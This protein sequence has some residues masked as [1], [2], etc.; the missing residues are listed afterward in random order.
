MNW[1]WQIIG[2]KKPTSLL[3]MLAV[4]LLSSNLH[5]ASIDNAHQIE[6]LNY[7]QAL[8]EYFQQHQLKAITG[9]LVAEQKSQ[10][11]K[12][13]DESD[14]LLADLYYAYGLFVESD[15]LFSRLL[16]E[17]TDRALLNRVWFNLARL[18]HDQGIYDQALKLLSQID[19]SLPKH[20]QDEKQYFLTNLFLSDLKFNDASQA[21]QAIDRESIWYQYARYNLGVSL[22]ENKR[23]DE[24]KSQLEP[25]GQL[26]TSSEE[27]LALRDRANLSLGLSQLRNARAEASIASFERIRL[28]GPLSHTALL[29]TGWAWNSLYQFDKA[30]VPWLELARKNTIDPA[31]QEA[32]LAIPTA[33][34]ENQKPKLAVQ[35]YEL[36][37]N[38]FDKQLEVL[39]HS[40]T[41]IQN[42]ELIS[43][44]NENALV[45]EGA[46]YT[47][48]SL[49]SSS[50]PYL[51]ILLASREFQR[52]LKRYQ[53]LI[54]IS[55]TL[56]HWNFNLPTLALML[57]ERRQ[58]F[59]EK[60][61]LLEQTSNFDHLESLN[62][63]RSVF[64]NQ[65]GEIESN[66]DYLGLATVEENEQLQRLNKVSQTLVS[67][68]EQSDTSD[69]QDMHRLLSGLLNWQINTSYASR[70]WAAQKQLN[71]L[72]EALSVATSRADSLRQITASSQ[73]KFDDFEL[74]IQTQEKKIKGLI[75]RIVDLIER[76]E[77]L[78]VRLAISAIDV[79]KQHIV[80]L[81]LNARYALARLY[82]TMVSE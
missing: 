71:G 44:L 37:A 27:T 73:Q 53:E 62:K 77:K 68:G 81:R 2:D 3:V 16:N 76:Q 65:L 18:N 66:K 7:G 42:G 13:R 75:Q 11:R 48:T 41:T 14:L 31:T 39:D 70:L 8:F 46:E 23:L 56:N 32:L 79:Q 22:L 43:L 33:L 63:S 78:I 34:E 69:E 67:I 58:R 10:T 59:Q 50:A 19:D 60:L 26:Q 55:S 57:N 35:Y 30:L 15:R 9:L 28:E 36:A 80:Q 20:L 51:H 21:L 6:D 49:R 74:R 17:D 72:D 12:Q 47:A 24:G 29:A 40:T 5:A 1:F 38:Q 54:D 4:G 25:L 64:A 61:P 82:D 52:E 45:Y